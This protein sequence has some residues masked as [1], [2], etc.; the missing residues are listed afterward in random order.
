VI[1]GVFFVVMPDKAFIALKN[2]SKVFVN[3]II[4]LI[5][6]FILLFCINLFLKPSHI[7]RFLGKSSGIKGL[8]EKGAKNSLIAIFLG[9]RAVKPFLLPIMVSYFGWIY[10]LILTVF[11][12]FGSL[13]VGYFVD[14]LIREKPAN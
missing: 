6:V 1:Y 10:V 14:A 5:F 12:I 8:R 2:T 13:V 4:P 7:V 9:N 3:I 11:T